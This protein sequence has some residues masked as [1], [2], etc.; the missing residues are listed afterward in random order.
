MTATLGAG[1]VNDY[2]ILKYTKLIFGLSPA[3]SRRRRPFL[4]ASEMSRKLVSPVV[5]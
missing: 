4:L 5:T 1:V 2:P 3:A